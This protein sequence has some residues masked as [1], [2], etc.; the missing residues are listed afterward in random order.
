MH[1]MILIILIMRMINY[2]FEPSLC[3][4]I[5]YAFDAD[6]SCYDH[7]YSSQSSIY[8]YLCDNFLPNENEN[9]NFHVVPA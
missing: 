6:D 4:S 9:E 2:S 7:N 3:D 1:T 8:E 5:E